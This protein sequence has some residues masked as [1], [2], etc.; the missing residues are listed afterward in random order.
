MR[1]NDERLSDSELLIKNRF[2]DYMSQMQVKMMTL[3]GINNNTNDKKDSDGNSHCENHD[4]NNN[5]SKRQQLFE[6]N[7]EEVRKE[8]QYNFKER[9]KIENHN[10][11]QKISVLVKLWSWIIG[12]KQNTVCMIKKTLLIIV[13]MRIM[14]KIIIKAR[15]NDYLKRILKKLEKNRSIILRRE[16]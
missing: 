9:E 12:V 3:Q 1:I 16:K 10:G 5:K 2:Q 11:Y 6:E 8:L 15:D 14:I 7:L 4:K 13:I